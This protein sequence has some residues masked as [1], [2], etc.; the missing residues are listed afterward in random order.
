MSDRPI[1]PRGPMSGRCSVCGALVEQG[2]DFNAHARFNHK[3]QWVRFLAKNKI[4]D[5]F[6]PEPTPLEPSLAGEVLGYALRV[7][8]PCAYNT[9]PHYNRFTVDQCTGCNSN[10]TRWENTT[11]LL[12]PTPDGGFKRK[13]S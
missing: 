10:G 12:E 1:I 9:C 4:V 8:Y 13:D 5:T 7:L 3:G 11:I 6:V 2:D